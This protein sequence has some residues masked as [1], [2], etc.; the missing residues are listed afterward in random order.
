ML[1]LFTYDFI[2]RAFLIGY[3]CAIIAAILGN[4][5]VAGRQAVMSDMLAHTSLAGVGIGVL[6]NL[7]PHFVAAAVSV[8]ASI[9]LYFLGRQKKLPKEAISVLILSGGIA[10]ALLCVHLAKNNPIALET[11]LFG[12][13]LTVTSQEVGMF[14]LMSL[15][16]IAVITLLYN[17]FLCFIFDADFFRSKFKFGIYFEL[18]FM[19]MIGAFVALSLKI[20]GGLLISSLLVVPVLTAQQ[21]AKSFRAS[22]LISVIVNLIGITIGILSS[23]YFDVPASSAV[24]LSLILLFVG[25]LFFAHVSRKYFPKLT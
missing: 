20:I 25:A 18:L 4:F 2:L 22:L 9:L 12:S 23:F 16:F 15:L 19:V 3:A 5:L 8:L 1:E 7:T 17:R 13:I 21:F 6:F 11:Y 10:I 24:V 14:I